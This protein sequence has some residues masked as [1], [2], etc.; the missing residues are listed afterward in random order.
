MLSSTESRDCVDTIILNLYTNCA[1]SFCMTKSA[2]LGDLQC[3][4]NG[5]APRY[6]ISR[7][8]SLKIIFCG[9]Q[10]ES[11]Y[12]RDLVVNY[13]MFIACSQTGRYGLNTYSPIDTHVYKIHSI[14]DHST[15]SAPRILHQAP[16]VLLYY[17]ILQRFGFLDYLCRDR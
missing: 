17:I 3:S 15:S 9:E 6:D 5:Y 11:Q 7:E 12:H 16:K 2:S 10:M 14:K 8:I 13:G 1:F 4:S